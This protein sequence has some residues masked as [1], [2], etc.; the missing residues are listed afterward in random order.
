MKDVYVLTLYSG[1]A[2][3]RGQSNVNEW[4]V[5]IPSNADAPVLD[6]RWKAHVLFA[7][8]KGF[9]STAACR[10]IGVYSDAFLHSGGDMALLATEIAS[11]GTTATDY[12]IIN[13]QNY[14]SIADP[15][16]L[17]KGGSFKIRVCHVDAADPLNASA[18]PTVGD[19]TIVMRFEMLRRKS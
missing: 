19:W 12:A 10:V 11:G 9:V 1:N 15:Y 14:L 8:V 6:G 2:T 5:T 13:Q 16:L 18:K 4:T 17:T 3:S 7:S